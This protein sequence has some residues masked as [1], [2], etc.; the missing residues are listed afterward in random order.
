MKTKYVVYRRVSTQRQGESGLGLEAQTD[1]VNRFIRSSGGEVVAQLTEIESGKSAANRPVLLE[2]IR[3]CKEHG[4]TLLVAKLDR[5][6]RNLHFVTT[7]QQSKVNFVAADNPH[8]TT[9]LIHILVAVAE[10]ERAAISLR[11]SSALQAAKRRG[12]R[13]GNPH[14]KEAVAKATKALQQQ[15]AERN[16]QLRQIVVE[17]MAKTGL[18]T[19][20]EVANCLNMRGIKTSRG[21]QFTPTHIHRL[22]KTA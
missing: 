11:T 3:S 21:C 12:V 18:Q 8:A 17:T 7:L 10:N 22:L 2:A 20:A 19:L 4:H 15:A 9:F 16:S 14:Y 1:A 5:L 6:T 13:L